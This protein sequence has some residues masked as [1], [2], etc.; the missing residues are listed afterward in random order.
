M[1]TLRFHIKMFLI[2][3]LTPNMGRSYFICHHYGSDQ[4]ILCAITV[5]IVMAILIM[6]NWVNCSLIQNHMNADNDLIIVP[7]Q[8]THTLVLNHD[9][10]QRKAIMTL[11][12]YENLLSSSHVFMWIYGKIE[13]WT[14]EKKKYVCVYL[15]ISRYISST[16]AKYE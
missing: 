4:N 12:T 6:V 16:P 7:Y 8:M 1:L 13:E 5:L 2:N 9:R 11:F 14:T 10:N 15:S 3:L